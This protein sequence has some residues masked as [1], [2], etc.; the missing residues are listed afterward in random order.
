MPLSSFAL[1]LG[2]FF[3][4]SGFPMVFLSQK[5][6]VW[7]RRMFKDE[8]MLRVISTAFVMISVITLR[9]QWQIS[10]DGEGFVV[11]FAWCVLLKSLFVAWCPLMFSELRERIADRLS[12]VPALELF[13]GIF[14][15]LL[16]AV[17]TYFG[18]LLPA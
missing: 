8:T 17:F 12:D 14:L 2:A 18:V 16:G 4:L 15:V 1:I 5:F 13:A 3:Y 9:R 6:L 7:Q 11:L 10:A